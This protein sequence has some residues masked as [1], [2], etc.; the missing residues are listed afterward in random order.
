MLPN[1]KVLP[2]ACGLDLVCTE[3][4]GKCMFLRCFFCENDDAF[5]F[6]LDSRDTART[7][8]AVIKKQDERFNAFLISPPHL[9]ILEGISAPRVLF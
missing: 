7:I 1:N 3:V 4:K 6:I 2:C 5:Q 8:N 9:G